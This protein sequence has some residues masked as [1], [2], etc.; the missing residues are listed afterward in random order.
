MST[1]AGQ[2]P[3]DPHELEDHEEE[4]EG[5]LEDPGQGAHH[6]GRELEEGGDRRDVED[7]PEDDAEHGQGGDQLQHPGHPEAVPV[8]EAGGPAL[9][10][11]EHPVGPEPVVGGPGLGQQEVGLADRLQ[12]HQGQ[13]P[14]LRLERA[15]Q[16]RLEGQDRVVGQFGPDEE[17]EEQAEQ[18]E[19]LHP[20]PQR[21]R[22]S[23]LPVGLAGAGEHARLGE[24]RLGVG[25]GRGPRGDHRHGLSPP[26][27]S[28]T[29]RR[30]RRT[31][32]GCPRSSG[33]RTS[34]RGG[35]SRWSA[36]RPA[37]CGRPS[38]TG[39]PRGPG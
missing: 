13:H 35:R 24:A 10:A 36:G 20:V 14:P 29:S 23:G 21:Q 34:S 33:P 16:R 28:S 9:E 30:W 26:G 11:P 22:L 31:R 25:G 17:P 19:E 37:P 15:V 32:H 8:V 2:E 18:Q 6:P 27:R 39:R 1:P 7:R 3:E 38:R 5:E 12:T 4:P